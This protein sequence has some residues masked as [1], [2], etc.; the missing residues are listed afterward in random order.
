MGHTVCLMFN[1]TACKEPCGICGDVAEPEI[2]LELFAYVHERLDDE[3]IQTRFRA[4]CYDC[5]K[6]HA[7]ELEIARRIISQSPTYLQEAMT[8]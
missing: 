1:N 8:A 3:T 6:K 2:G 4:I 5:G 7:P